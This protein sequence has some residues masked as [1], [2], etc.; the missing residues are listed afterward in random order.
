MNNVST[1]S[2][3]SSENPGFIDITA[4]ED[5]PKFNRRQLLERIHSTPRIIMFEGQNGGCEG[6]GDSN[7]RGGF[8]RSASSRF[9]TVSSPLSISHQQQESPPSHHRSGGDVASGARPSLRNSPGRGVGL[10]RAVSERHFGYSSSTATS[11]IQ[12]NFQV[13]SKQERVKLAKQISQDLCFT[14]SKKVSSSLANIDEEVKEDQQQESTSSSTMNDRRSMFERMTSVPTLFGFGGGNSNVSSPS[15]VTAATATTPTST[16]SSKSRSSF[17]NDLMLSASEASPMPS[18]K[19]TSPSSS[20]S[21]SPTQEASSSRRSF[22]SRSLSMRLPYPSPWSGVDGRA[23][24]EESSD[25]KDGDF[26]FGLDE[27]DEELRSTLSKLKNIAADRKKNLMNKKTSSPSCT[28][29]TITSCTEK[30]NKKNETTSFSAPP[31]SSSSSSLRG[32]ELVTSW[33]EEIALE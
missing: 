13:K 12:V 26:I 7:R 6:D 30:N 22:F 25:S 28:K 24:K 11:P 29:A 2:G 17:I 8:L 5:I 20:I 32:K 31:S 27:R 16:D 15:T 4:K 10:S 23:S 21:S 1:I 3:I 19:S 9:A 18:L 33:F 14:P